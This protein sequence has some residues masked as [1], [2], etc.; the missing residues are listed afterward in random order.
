MKITILNLAFAA[1]LAVAQPHN[2]GHGHFHQKKR[3][4]SA[5]DKRGDVVVDYVP[6]Y[7]TVYKIGDE[8]VTPEEAKAG[9]DNGLYIVVGE[10]TP[11]YSAPSAPSITP[12]SSPEYAAQFIEKTSTTTSS[13]TTSSTP[14]PSTTSTTSSV[15]PATTSQ[16]SS[17][18]SSGTTGIDAEFPS[19]EIDCDTFPSDYGAYALDWLDTAGWASL[20]YTPNYS[21]GDAAISY[22]VSGVTGDKCKKKGFCSY[23]CPPGYMK[24]QWPEDSQ[25]LTGQSIGGLYCNADGKLELTRP[26]VKQLCIEGVG[27]VTIVNKLSK[28]AAVCR[29]DYPGLENM[30]IPLDTQPGN[31][32]TLANVDSSTYYEWEGMATTFQYYVN[33]QGISVEDACVWTSPVKPLAAGNW[34]P[35][36]IGVGRDSTGTTYLSIFPNSPTSVATLDF[37]IEISGDFSGSCSLKSG[38]Y[39]GSD[40]GCTI[41]IPEGGNAVLTFVDSS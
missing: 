25:G 27:G 3:G 1:S 6:A 39:E 36:I 26:K 32:Y 34:A 30:V 5:V 10:T 2:H 13:S 33:P 35:T 16:A 4:D 11:T 22:I 14:V 23:A 24:S 20:Q 38:T 9:L 15:A 28:G 37:D 29:T 31:T 12:T 21:I 7:A 17:G 19:G 18:G 40:S 8:E 41:G